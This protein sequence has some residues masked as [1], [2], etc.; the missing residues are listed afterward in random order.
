MITDTLTNEEYHASKAISSSDVKAVLTSSIYHWRNKSF[1]ETPAMALGTAVH[2]MALE[3]G[4]NTVRG[5]ETRRGAAWKDLEAECRAQGK[6]LLPE[7]EYDTA[8]NIVEA[9]M[10]DAPSQKML[11]DDGTEFEMSIFATCPTTGLELRCRPDIMHRKKAV[12][13]DI[14]TTV[15]ASPDGFTR[16]IYNFR[17]DVQA[18]F[19]TYVA[20][21]AGVKISHFAFLAV[22]NSH[23]HA[24]HM[25]VMSMEALKL[26]HQDMMYGLKKIAEAKKAEDYSTG[27]PRFTM[28]YPPAWMNTAE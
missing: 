2:D 4:H 12:L 6:V 1:K 7:K 19:Y 28:I 3:G 11:T 21:L 13:G 14:K 18:A 15:D 26:G 8:E 17:Y 23:P 20:E 9:I 25:H 5:P 10:R 24:A 22:E 16:Q 27:W